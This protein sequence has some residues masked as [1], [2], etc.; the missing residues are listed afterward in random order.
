[1]RIVSPF[2]QPYDALLRQSQDEHFWLRKPEKGSHN[3][4]VDP[5]ST[6]HFLVDDYKAEHVIFVVNN[7]MIPVILITAYEPG[8]HYFQNVK[9]LHQFAYGDYHSF[10]ASELVNKEKYSNYYTAVIN[11]FFSQRNKEC[12]IEASVGRITFQRHGYSHT[13]EVNSQFEDAF[14]SVLKPYE[15]YHEILYWFNNKSNP[16]KPMIQI[17]NEDRIKQYGFDKMSFRKRKE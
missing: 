6:Y 2:K 7:K 14:F 1:M 17:S 16:E 11:K 12:V 15:V 10:F 8:Y 3:A 4:L 13:L 9:I 5:G